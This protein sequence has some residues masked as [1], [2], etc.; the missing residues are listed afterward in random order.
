MKTLSIVL[1]LLVSA[2]GS[3]AFGACTA[4]QV[5]VTTI[6]Q[7]RLVQLA[8]RLPEGPST[9]ALLEAAENAPRSRPQATQTSATSSGGTDTTSLADGADKPS[10][11]GLAVDSG[12]VETGDGKLTLH[13]NPFS[14]RT[15]L[16][17]ASWTDQS[18]Y[19][20]PTNTRLRQ[21]GATIGLGGKGE[22]FDRDGDG[23]ADE[24]LASKD[25]S[26]IINWE[27]SWRPSKS[28]DRREKYNWLEY[29][30]GL[31]PVFLEVAN[32]TA[33]IL[34]RLNAIPAWVKLT[35]SSQCV[36]PKDLDDFLKTPEVVAIIRPELLTSLAS[37][38]AA[39][40]AKA[41]SV[42][43]AIENKPVYSLVAG[44]T[45]RKDE[46]GPDKVFIA[47]RGDKP[48]GEKQNLKINAE[49]ARMNDLI[50]GKDPERAYASAEFARL[51]LKDSIFSKEG[52]V[53]SFAAKWAHT[54]NV[55][56]AK[57][58]TIATVGGKVEIPLAKGINFPISVTWAN[59]AD[60]LTEQSEIVGHFGFT[61]DVASLLAPKK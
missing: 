45:R 18:Q 31:S 46:F 48:L 61:F 34:A 29:A 51:I 52:L 19:M 20:N 13:L 44:G 32:P 10:L 22:S 1:A 56:D 2:S 7:D 39:F 24:A 59:H 26:D 50:G 11:F 12:L 40:D 9:E 55:P 41:A 57:H 28:R 17:T 15:L 58:P 42:T 14:I 16:H 30:N 38:K 25:I 60:L 54:R 8:K 23:K 3:T 43:E 47:F 49:W 27:V 53:A 33:Q 21:F 6:L 5:D 36:V 37:A 35:G 4:P